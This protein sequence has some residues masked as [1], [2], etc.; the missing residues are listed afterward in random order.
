MAKEEFKLLSA[1]ETCTYLFGNKFLLTNLS[2]E[3]VL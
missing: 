2:T 1:R 3:N